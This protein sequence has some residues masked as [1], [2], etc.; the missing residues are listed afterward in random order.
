VVGTDFLRLTLAHARRPLAIRALEGVSS[1]LEGFEAV[2]LE[3]G[4]PW[5]LRMVQ[6]VSSC[7]DARRPRLRWRARADVRE[8][9]VAYGI[10]ERV[11]ELADD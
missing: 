5:M 1:Y 3:G 9:L 4:P 6:G 2:R 7:E 11:I 8:M 10:A